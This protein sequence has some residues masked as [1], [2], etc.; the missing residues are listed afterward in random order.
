MR[1]LWKLRTLQQRSSG[2]WN[3]YAARAS[4]WAPFPLCERRKNLLHPLKPF[5]IPCSIPVLQHRRP[6]VP[7]SVINH[8]GVTHLHGFSYR[9]GWGFPRVQVPKPE[10]PMES[11]WGLPHGSDNPGWTWY[12]WSISALSGSTSWTS[13]P[14]ALIERDALTP[15]FLQDLKLMVPTMLQYVRF[16][17]NKISLRLQMDFL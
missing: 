13:S 1:L 17:K 3:N 4:N 14:S 5:I 7:P 10:H 9:A 11:A 8:Y 12:L 2:K 16:I 15:W 6:V